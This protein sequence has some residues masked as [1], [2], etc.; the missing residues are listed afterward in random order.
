MRLEGRIW[1]SPTSKYWLVEVPDP[2]PVSRSRFV[3]CS[4]ADSP[5]SQDRSTSTTTCSAHATASP[6]RSRAAR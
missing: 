6:F 4:S 3:R 2:G 5:V 1:K